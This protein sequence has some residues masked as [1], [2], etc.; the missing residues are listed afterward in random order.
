MFQLSGQTEAVLACSE[1]RLGSRVFTLSYIS[2]D[3]D[4]SEMGVCPR[5]LKSF[6][7]S[8]TLHSEAMRLSEQETPWFVC[9]FLSSSTMP[10]SN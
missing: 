7:S 1:R 4:T 3:P 9:I 6:R 2:D 8:E 10:G 5:I